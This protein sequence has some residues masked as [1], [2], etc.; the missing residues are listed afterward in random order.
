VAWVGERVRELADPVMNGQL[1]RGGLRGFRGARDT[2]TGRIDMD[3]SRQ[4]DVGPPAP[5]R[6]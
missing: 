5:T 2:W 6:L 3:G 4:S 1:I